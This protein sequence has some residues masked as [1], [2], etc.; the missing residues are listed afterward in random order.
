MKE[1]VF[2]QEDAILRPDI[3]EQI[4]SSL[5]S[6]SSKIEDIILDLAN[7]YVGYSHLVDKIGSILSKYG[8]RGKEIVYSQ[9]RDV[10]IKFFEQP[11]KVKR[12]NQIL[13]DNP[14]PPEWVEYITREEIWIN[15]ILKLSQN[16][17]RSLFLMYCISKIC[18]SRPDLIK[19]LPTGCLS[20][21][22]YSN[23]F[24][25][26]ISSMNGDVNRIPSTQFNW[27]LSIITSDDI[28]LLH[29]SLFCFQLGNLEFTDR[30]YSGLLNSSKSDAS[31]F[32]SVYLRL[33]GGNDQSILA[34]TGRYPLS[35]KE[36]VKKFLECSR[37]SIFQ[38]LLIDKE[39]HRI[40]SSSPDESEKK[41]V[42][43]Y[44]FRMANIPIQ[45]DDD[46]NQGKILFDSVIK[47]SFRLESSKVRDL[48]KRVVKSISHRFFAVTLIKCM[49]EN[50]SKSGIIIISSDG[51]RFSPECEFIEEIMFKWKDLRQTVVNLV[52][53]LFNHFTV[54]TDRPEDAELLLY[55]LSFL[56]L[57]YGYP[58]E[59]L[60]ALANH[61][62][63]NPN[64]LRIFIRKILDIIKPPFSDEYCLSLL[65]LIVSEK[66]ERALSDSR[67]RD[68][69]KRLED[70]AKS[71]QSNSFE[72]EKAKS[73]ALV[74]L[75]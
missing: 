25:Y 28:S 69:R 12:L 71:V 56:I 3:E 20:Y 18:S 38:S 51:A 15:S 29:A 68:E 22:D 72:I 35:P 7:G 46:F 66:T 45:S 75:K 30:V 6:G 50:V 5:E 62:P 65:N 49:K 2:K 26:I 63:R 54:Q 19:S 8:Y 59:I 13:I 41:A 67:L 44:Y 10:F 4:R 74:K 16:N 58:I 11:D 21:Q 23:L 14:E 27:F 32:A 9:A 43:E 64:N 42:I 61:S 47:W 39:L 36:R 24:T 52:I 1:K 37:K 17:S 33:E 73:S 70:W 57:T 55:E 53:W 31:R 40:L 48:C 60:G 34:T